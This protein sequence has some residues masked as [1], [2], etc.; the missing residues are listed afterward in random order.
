ME[1]KIRR[2]A[3]ADIHVKMKKKEPLKTVLQN[4]CEKDK[5]GLRLDMLHIVIDAQSLPLDQ[6][7]TPEKA[8]LKDGDVVTLMP[9]MNLSVKH[10]DGSLFLVKL[11]RDGKLQELLRVISARK[12]LDTR[13]IN[14]EFKEAAIDPQQTPE[15]AGLKD[16]D[17]IEAFCCLI[18]AVVDD[19]QR[20]TDFLI[21]KHTCLSRLLDQ[22]CARDGL[23]KAQWVLYE[24]RSGKA[25]SRTA[26]AHEL[27]LKDGDV[28]HMRRVLPGESRVPN[29]LRS[30]FKDFWRSS[31]C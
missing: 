2:P 17:V 31:H 20:S 8:G 3:K 25:L 14:L 10:E 1:L 23:D 30:L 28:L 26:K 16:G 12:G 19:N 11:R 4:I 7:M 15:Q 27:S 6:S 21:S 22:C 29:F 13:Q 24:P 18:L 9:L 5:R